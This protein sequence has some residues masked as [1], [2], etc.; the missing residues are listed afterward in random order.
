MKQ[1][2]ETAASP[3][4]SQTDHSGSTATPRELPTPLGPFRF[5]LLSVSVGLVA[6]VGAVVFRGLIAVIHNLMFL[7]SLSFSYDANTHTP[8]GPWGAAVILVPVA[9]ALIVAFLV[10]NFGPE[11]KGHGVPE[12]MDAIYYR[13]GVIRPVVALVKALASALSIGSGGSVGREGPI[14][15]I[16]ASFGST[17]GQIV[18]MPV[19]ERNTLI[20]AGAGAGIAAT[21]NTPVGGILFA[22]EL[23][24]VEISV[25]T[26]VPVT[27]ATVTATYIGQVFFG[28]HPSFVIPAFEI[29]YFHL[30]SPWVL[31]SY[32]GLGVVAG[33]VSAVFIRAIYATEDFFDK[34]VPGNYYSRHALGM[35]LVGITMYALM[36]T[37]GNYYVEG[38]GYAT[39]QDILTN[40][41][42]SLPFLLLLLLLKLMVTS[43]TLGSGASGGIFSPSLFLGAALG[44]CYGIVLHWLL[45]GL[46]VSPAAFA[47][48]G[49]AG[50]VSGA[51]GAALA[52]IVMIFEMTLDYSVIVPITITVGVSYGV[53]TL[54]LADSIYTLKL[55]RR[56]KQIPQTLQTNIEHVRQVKDLMDTRVVAFAT[57]TLLEDMGTVVNKEM[58]VPTVLAYDDTGIVGVLGK[59]DLLAALALYDGKIT[60]GDIASKNYVIVGEEAT[61][62]D[63]RSQMHRG[64]ATTALVIN[65]S[66]I[67]P[68]AVIGIITR[69]QLAD[70]VIDA[71]ELLSE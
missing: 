28:T 45:P 8:L 60:L 31:A 3:A 21:F 56:G 58:G 34:Y 23:M 65:G 1:I 40:T 48:A 10:N 52:A 22:I 18:R 42:T 16:G 39:I 70:A 49:M 5:T 20:A 6:G 25:R 4:A 9:G 13:K 19:W 15:Q 30:A 57:T 47:V 61:F 51:T 62:F 14:I 44:G 17:L 50:V 55:T 32:V 46:H 67:L 68:Q 63:V 71:T 2:S 35:L 53:R 59:Q 54:F 38:V 66:E 7:G 27:I 26:L 37:T 33:V 11:A 43:L 69:H 29:T 24:M 36:A 64:N 12:V 41:L